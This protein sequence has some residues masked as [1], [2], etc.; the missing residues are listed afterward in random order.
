MDNEV[1]YLV[2]NPT[3]HNKNKLRSWHPSSKM[4]V[5]RIYPFG[6]PYAY[7]RESIFVEDPK[8]GKFIGMLSQ[9]FFVPATKEDI[10]ELHQV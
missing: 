6:R 1:E 2:F 3:Y 8:T 5:K 10:D 4:L 7:D 9:D